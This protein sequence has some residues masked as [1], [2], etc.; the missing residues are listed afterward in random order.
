MDMD[1]YKVIPAIVEALKQ[2]GFRI[3][4]FE[5]GSSAIKLMI[6]PC[7]EGGS[8]EGEANE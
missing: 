3:V 2:I 5:H 7:E 4:S 8:N 1:S 6:V